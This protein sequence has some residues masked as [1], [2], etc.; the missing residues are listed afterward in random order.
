MEDPQGNLKEEDKDI[1][2]ILNN[3]FSSVF[4]DEDCSN[5]PN[6]KPMVLPNQGAGMINDIEISE[7][8]VRKALNGVKKNKAGGTDEIPSNLILAVS[9]ALV[10]PITA[11]FRSSFDSSDIPEDWKMANVTALFKKGSKKKRPTIGLLV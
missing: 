1:C 9:E 8:I 2:D 4:T 3:Y 7:V 6:P 10:V 11:I 5:I